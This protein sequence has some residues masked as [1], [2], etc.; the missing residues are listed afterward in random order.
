MY[1]IGNYT[2]VA[3][4]TNENTA[5]SKLSLQQQISNFFFC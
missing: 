3:F 1:I 2:K 5:S 4:D